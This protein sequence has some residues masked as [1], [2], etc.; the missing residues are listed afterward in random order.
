VK[1]R[2]IGLLT[3]AAL[4]CASS[5]ALA[6]DPPPTLQPGVLTVG[7]S[8]PSPGFQVGAVS[9]HSVVFAR[10]LEIDLANALAARLGI[11]RVVF[12][13][14]PQFP[15]LIAGGPK[16][17]D[18]ALGEVTITPERAA[19]IT[20]SVPYMEADQGVLLRRGLPSTPKT[21]AQL[22]RL[23]LCSQA[24]T[25]S[26]TVIATR[27]KPVKPAK[28]YGNTT[29]MLNALQ[30]GR[31]C[32]AVVYDAAIL[33]TLRAEVPLRYGPIAGTIDTGENYGVVLPKDSVLQPVIDQALDGLMTNGALTTITRR[34][35]S[36]DLTKL[37]TLR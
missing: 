24:A 33:A 11:P 5:L 37:P 35:L 4:L 30:A 19:D 8:M 7:V 3:A 27:V 32:D 14:E 21:I 36:T 18:I 10:G 15:R 6:A 16:P 20:F 31:R 2:L 12:Y 25:T 26:A 22:S 17:W 34:W 13:Q 9:G 23:K 29:L 28:L 1:A